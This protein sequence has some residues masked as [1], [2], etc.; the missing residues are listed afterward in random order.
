[1]SQAH[2]QGVAGRGGAKAG[3]KTMLGRGRPH[4]PSGGA[5]P[6]R[7]LR[8]S[9]A[10][11][12]TEAAG[13]RATLTLPDVDEGV[14]DD[15]LMGLSDGM[16]LFSLLCDGEIVGLLA[17]DAQLRMAVVEAQTLGEPYHAQVAERPRTSVDEVLCQPVAERCIGD[18]IAEA[19]ASPTQGW[20]VQGWVDGL[21]CGRPF[22]GARDAAFA[23]SHGAYR[24]MR[25]GV[26][27]SNDRAG[28]ITLLLPT[29]G[30]RAAVSQ[31]R[32]MAED[33]PS[34]AVEAS[35]SRHAGWSLAINRNVM[36]AN[37][38]LHA[39]LHRMR[40]PLSQIEGL[41]VGDVLSLPGA[42]L[43]A[44]RLIGAGDAQV[45][46]GHLGKAGGMRALRLTGAAVTPDEIDALNLT[47][48]WGVTIGMAG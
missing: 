12:L 30:A 25:I 35:R 41:A 27:I 31:R 43:G 22:N 40:I 42:S 44:V 29:E 15:I 26:A 7:V 36:A 24:Q 46:F 38:E 6:Q 39:V 13:L 32:K 23:L 11:A 16:I 2:D 19:I 4:I 1:M 8:Q 47:Q 18:L 37:A 9:F 48:G 14:L 33:A 17:F 28:G 20:S 3:I 34:R 5:A 45:G 21:A 10:R